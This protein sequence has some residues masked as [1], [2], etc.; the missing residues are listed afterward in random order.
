MPFV[1][2]VRWTF[3]GKDAGSVDSGSIG[4]TEDAA[5]GRPARPG[6]TTCISPNPSYRLCGSTSTT[7]ANPAL[8]IAGAATERRRAA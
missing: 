8:R 6:G 4:A 7:A 5:S 2:G 1:A 3:R